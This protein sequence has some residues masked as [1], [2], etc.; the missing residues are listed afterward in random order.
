MGGGNG[1][2]GG[3]E[4]PRGIGK[5]YVYIGEALTRMHSRGRVDT[6]PWSLGFIGLHNVYAR[7]R[8]REFRSIIG[9]SHD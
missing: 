3:I 5:R 7:S 2:R 4:T 1:A 8:S 6:L 9:E